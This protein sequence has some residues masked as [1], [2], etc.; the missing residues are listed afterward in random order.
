MSLFLIAVVVFL[1]AAAMVRW[2]SIPGSFLFILDHPNERSLHEQP[3]P[4]N[5]GVGIVLALL[6]GGGA[7]SVSYGEVF[8]PLP[9]LLAGIAVL[10]VVSYLDD[11]FDVRQSYRLILHVAVAVFVNIGGLGLGELRLPGI[12]LE[13]WAGAGF[14]LTLLYVVWMINLYNFMD[15]MD[16]FAAGMA[17]MGFGTY[18]LL[19]WQAGSETFAAVCLLV[20]AASAGFLLFNFPPARIFM[21][22]VGSI[23]LGFL[24]A[25]LALWA[26]RDGLFPLWVALIVFSPFI[27]DATITL[28]GRV[29]HRESFWKAHRSH[30]YQRLV[31][32]GWGH[33]RTVLAEYI[34]MLACS[35]AA[36][37]LSNAE[38]DFQWSG[39]VVLACLYWYLEAAVCRL[40]SKSMAVEEEK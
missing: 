16:G 30:Y 4:R 20:M 11:R 10:G 17:V 35:L 18:G 38:P 2:L 21:G 23:V 13:L 14:V 37:I 29:W 15:G 9:L 26:Q 27:V 40:E 28:I 25:A 39:L 1:V 34:L 24:A 33:R 32:L 6:L 31:R 5:G 7:L 19:G 12:V 22:D 3:I 36:L 8:E